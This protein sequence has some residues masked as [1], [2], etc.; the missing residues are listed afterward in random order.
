MTTDNMR[1]NDPA[2]ARTYIRNLAD[3]FEEPEKML[4][5]LSACDMAQATLA[6]WMFEEHRYDSKMRAQHRRGVLI[7]RESKRELE[8]IWSD[9]RQASTEFQLAKEKL[10]KIISALSMPNGDRVLVESSTFSL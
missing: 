3:Q 4:E 7:E 5:F 8:I 9:Y 1:L 10:R 6:H 2:T